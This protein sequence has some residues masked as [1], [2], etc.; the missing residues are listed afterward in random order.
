MLILCQLE[1]AAAACAGAVRRGEVDEE[2]GVSLQPRGEGYGHGAAGAPGV[3]DVGG[4][5]GEALFVAH[6]E[7][8]GAVV[9]GAVGVREVVVPRECPRAAGGGG[10]AEVVGQLEVARGEGDFAEV[11]HG[12]FAGEPA[13]VVL[14]EVVVSGLAAFG[15]GA[16]PEGGETGFLGS[17]VECRDACH[18]FFL[19]AG[20][21]GHDQLGLVGQPARVSLPVVAVDNQVFDS[22]FNQLYGTCFDNH[23]T[24]FCVSKCKVRV[25]MYKKFLKK[26]SLWGK[27][28]PRP[29]PYPAA[30]GA[31]A[32]SGRAG[33]G[34]AE[35]WR[36]GVTGKYG[37]SIREVWGRARA[38]CGGRRRK[39][40]AMHRKSGG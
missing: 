29:L 25:Q 23:G 33:G 40:I 14:H 2:V 36:C 26:A 20:C 5:D 31:A 8:E 34:L 16:R 6:D 32:G 7:G 3:G 1:V 37:G 30:P 11:A 38:A 18:A 22:T 24:G 9:G 27:Y 13:D 35:G 15:L 21:L 17:L 4:R 10:E 39:A 28:F 12:A 19:Q